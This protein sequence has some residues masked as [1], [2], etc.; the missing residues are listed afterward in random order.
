MQ[1]IS[2]AFPDGETVLDLRPEEL[3]LLILSYVQSIK[4]NQLNRNNFIND[5]GNSGFYVERVWAQVW[6]A[7]AEAWDW[8]VRAGMLAN[9]VGQSWGWVFITREGRRLLETGDV[10]AYLDAALFPR[11]GLDEALRKDV[12][13]LYLRSDFDT[14]VFRAFK[15]VEVRVREV[16]GLGPDDIGKDLARKAFRA[17]PPLGR[18]TDSA[19]LPAERQALS[20][21]FAGALGLFKNPSSHRDVPWNE[22][23]DC[24]EAISLA[25]LLLRI[26]ERRRRGMPKVD[27]STL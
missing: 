25:D 21:L 17:D 4:A 22:A 9:H 23:R 26:V 8:L 16:S 10:R 6:Q 20:D 7:F 24:A 15:E 18:L 3:G 5:V 12:L 2:K 14:A 19:Q 1:P 27:T 13:P 11:E